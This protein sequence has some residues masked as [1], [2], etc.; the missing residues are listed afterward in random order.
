MKSKIVAR[1]MITWGAPYFGPLSACPCILQPIDSPIRST[2]K[3]N[4]ARLRHAFLT[5]PS[6]MNWC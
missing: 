5:L 2:Q 4:P 3:E 1:N 6:L